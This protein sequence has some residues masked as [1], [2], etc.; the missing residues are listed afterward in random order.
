LPDPG[1]FSADHAVD[2]IENFEVLCQ[3]L[4]TIFSCVKLNFDSK[5][6]QL[7]LFVIN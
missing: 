6:E 3:Q 7:T 4:K 2:I 1:D 5:V